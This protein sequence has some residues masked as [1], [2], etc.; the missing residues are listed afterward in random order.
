MAASTSST[1]S[2]ICRYQLRRVGQRLAQHGPGKAAGTIRIGPTS[3]RRPPA[4]AAARLRG[5][6]ETGTVVAG[7][8]VDGL[9]DSCRPARD[10]TGRSRPCPCGRSGRA[11]IIRAISGWSRRFAAA[12]VVGRQQPRH[13]GGHLRRSG[14]CRP[15]RASRTRRSWECRPAA[16]STASASSTVQPELDRLVDRRLH[17]VAADPVGDEAGRV[18][19]EDHALAEPEIGERGRPPR[20]PRA[21]VSGPATTSSRR[22]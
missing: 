4:L 8:Q 2:A 10:A 13:A 3:A 16:P 9:L 6:L 5:D 20:P 19:A 7:V 15:D 17:P 11:A 12:R 18:L 14:R 22:M 21:R 1:V